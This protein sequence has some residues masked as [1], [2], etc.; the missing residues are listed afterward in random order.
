MSPILVRE[1]DIR[2]GNAL[3]YYPEAN[4]LVSTQTDPR[5]KTPAFKCVD[6]TLEPAGGARPPKTGI[7][8]RGCGF[9][10]G[11][12][13]DSSLAR[14]ASFEAALL[15]DPRLLWRILVHRER[16]NTYETPR[17]GRQNVATGGAARRQSRLPRNPW[18]APILGFAPDGATEA[19]TSRTVGEETIPPPLPGRFCRRGRPRVSLRSTRGYIPRPHPGPMQKPA[20]GAWRA[21]LQNSRVGLTRERPS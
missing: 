9:E 20:K 15:F 4:V 12:V 17:M 7:R 10:A 1:H 19:V 6:V 13:G 8:W 16:L 11:A 21:Q 18:K 5:S 14:R 2:A 3:M